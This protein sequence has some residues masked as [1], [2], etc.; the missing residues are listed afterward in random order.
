MNRE[1]DTP[2][3]LR[4]WNRLRISVGA[5]L[6][7]GARDRRLAWLDSPQ[8]RLQRDAVAAITAPAVK[9]GTNGNIK[10]ACFT[11]GN[12]AARGQNGWW[13]ILESITWAT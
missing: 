3:K 12:T 13:I 4:W 9:Y 1:M 5:F 8:R 6:R 7:A 11:R 2:K 10:T